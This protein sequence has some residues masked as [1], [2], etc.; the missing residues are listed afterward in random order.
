MLRVKDE[1]D[2]VRTQSGAIQNVNNDGYRT[3]I[4][5]RRAAL[6]TKERLE[7]LEKENKCINDK[8]DAILQLLKDKKNEE[9]SKPS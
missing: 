5:K 4:M 9:T 6:E 8:L 3:F 1:P 2:L 7:K